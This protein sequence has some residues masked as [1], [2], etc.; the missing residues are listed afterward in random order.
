MIT[1][2]LPHAMPDSH[3]TY[4]FAG[5]AVASALVL[6]ELPPAQTGSRPHYCIEVSAEPLLPTAGVDARHHWLDT[7]GTLTLT[8]L[9]CG[10]TYY[11]YLPGLAEARLGA[12][13]CVSVYRNPEVSLASLRHAIVDQILPRLLAGA[14]ALMTHAAAVIDPGARAL[15]LLGESGYGK[16]TLCAALVHS[17]AGLLSD[18][19]VRL[20]PGTEQVTVIPG[21]PGMRLRPDSLSALYAGQVPATTSVADHMDKRRVEL[22]APER[23]ASNAVVL[24][25]SAQVGAIVL[26]QPPGT[27]TAVTLTRVAP[28]RACMALVHNS[29]ALDPTDTIRVRA[30]LAKA[31]DVIQAVPAYTL[32]Y[33]RDYACLPGVMERLRRIKTATVL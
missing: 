23:R 32:G 15:L 16:S 2:N 1:A 22:L 3:C 9:R 11:L 14:G 30:Q 6:P 31:S 7:A 26:L 24:V 20:E 5:V 29:F 18:D 27:A 19:C 25:K 8:G 17:G 33:P 12:D 4:E 28:A 13:G 10:D 21:Y